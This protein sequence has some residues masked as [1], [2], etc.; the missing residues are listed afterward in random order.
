MKHRYLYRPPPKNHPAFLRACRMGAGAPPAADVADLRPFMMPVRDQGQEGCCSGFSTAALREALRS[1][2]LQTLAQTAFLSPA[3]LYARTRMVEGTFPD[4]AGA[5]IID[6]MNT[7]ENYG[8]CPET[9]LPYSGQASEAP[10][11]ACD[12]AAVPFRCGPPQIVSTDPAS[13]ESV[14]AANQPVVFGM[15][16]HPSFESTGSDGMV[17]AP[18]PGEECLGGHA[19]IAVGYIRPSQRVIVRNS[20]STSWGDK[21]YCYMPYS[22][23]ASW[24]ES[25]TAPIEP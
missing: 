15:P 9:L 2:A 14:L 17:V 6:E 24:F 19:L 25:W 4:D 8:V 18:G 22:M 3:Y 7:L 23:I 20:W 10:N 5:T 21:G 13:L 11:P 1:I 16:V 12:V